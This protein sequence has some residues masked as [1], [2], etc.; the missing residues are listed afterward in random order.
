MLGRQR[1]LLGAAGV[2]LGFV[3]AAQLVAAVQRWTC[4]D[5]PYRRADGTWGTMCEIVTR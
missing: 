4:G 5:R 3:V 1:T 2:V